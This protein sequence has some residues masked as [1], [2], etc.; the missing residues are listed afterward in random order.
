MNNNT[1]TDV[2]KEGTTCMAR[3]DEMTLDESQVAEQLYNSAGLGPVVEAGLKDYDRQLHQEDKVLNK[4]FGA[5]AGDIRSYGEAVAKRVALATYALLNR[6]YGGKVGNLRS[7]IMTLQDERD[8]A[9]SRYDELMGRVLGILGEEYRDLRIDS[10]ELMERLGDLECLR[11]QIKTLEEEK[12]QLKADDDC[13]IA[14]LEFEKMTLANSLESLR[15]DYEGMKKAMITL[16]ETL[17]D[18]ELR[19]RLSNE[20]YRYILEDSRVPDIVIGGVGKFIDFKKYLAAAADR[21]AREVCERI[22]GILSPT[23]P[24]APASCETK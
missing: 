23:G 20:L 11:A 6:E 5:R 10:K 19:R 4:V 1:N 15:E 13:E 21:G 3:I 18:E 2:V 16:V 14:C 7:Y 12:I 9:N 24:C 22:K 17:P 8:R